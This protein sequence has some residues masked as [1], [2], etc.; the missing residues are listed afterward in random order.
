[1][2]PADLRGFGEDS[3]SVKISAMM[4]REKLCVCE[5]SQEHGENRE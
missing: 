5:S 1:M 2:M 4:K 3:T